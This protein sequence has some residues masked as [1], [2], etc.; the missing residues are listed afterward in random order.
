[1]V[2]SNPFLD[3]AS[4]ATGNRDASSPFH[5]RT[6]SPNASAAVVLSPTSLDAEVHVRLPSPV[7]APE[8]D[9]VARDACLPTEGEAGATS[10]LR[11]T[12]SPGDT[13]GRNPRRATLTATFHRG[14][15]EEDSA[16]ES[17]SD[18]G[19]DEHDGNCFADDGAEHQEEVEEVLQDQAT[20]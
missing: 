8:V 9:A 2:S 14:E 12:M 15:D 18:E 11:I 20:L 19:E 17:E 3:Q 4:S 13:F 16:D 1:M 5:A 6:T 10:Q 7:A